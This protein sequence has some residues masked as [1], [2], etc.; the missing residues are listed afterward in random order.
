MKSWFY[1]VL[2]TLL[3]LMIALQL[4]G[5][6]ANLGL[7]FS[8]LSVS[9][10]SRKRMSKQLYSIN[11]ISSSI[12]FTCAL[13]QVGFFFL[14]FLAIIDLFN[15]YRLYNDLPV[16]YHQKFDEMGRNKKFKSV[17]G[18]DFKSKFVSFWIWFTILF[19]LMNSTL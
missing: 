11:W 1:F 8:F 2:R 6:R 16:I 14:T 12:Q 7:I 5:T 19:S 10:L 4:L 9:L 18:Y 15:L 3:W 13:I 17:R